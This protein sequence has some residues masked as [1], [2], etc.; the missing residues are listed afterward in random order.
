MLWRPTTAPRWENVEE[1]GDQTQMTL[2]R[3]KDNVIFAVR[4][5]D[6]KGHK[7][8]PVVPVPER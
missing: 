1:A 7:S 5:V 3:S 4:A 2:K 8:L 6:K